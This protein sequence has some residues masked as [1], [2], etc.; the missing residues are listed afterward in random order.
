MAGRLARI[1]NRIISTQRMDMSVTVATGA[2][3]QVAELWDAA[4]Q[5]RDDAQYLQDWHDLSLRDP[6]DRPTLPDDT[7]E[8]FKRIRKNSQTPWG[9]MIVN[10][11]AQGIAVDDIYLRG[12][13][14]SSPAYNVWQQNGLD[15]KQTPLVKGM[16]RHGY[17]YNLILP[18]VGRLDG[19]PT[20]LIRGKSA[21]RM[22]AFYRDDAD[23]FPEFALEVDRNGEDTYIWLYDDVYTHRMSMQGDDLRT[24][25]Y[26]DNEPHGMSICPVVRYADMDLDGNTYGEIAPFI[27]VF[28]RIDQDTCDRLIV[29]R[30]GA[31]NAR[32]G[33]GVKQPEGEDA[34]RRLRL[35]FAAG[36]LMMSDEP[37][38]KFGSLP[39]TPLDGYIAARE[40]DIR[41]L[42]ATSQTAPYRLLG[43][44]DNV[45]GDA[46]AAADKAHN[47]KVDE[48]RRVVGEGHE[49]SLRLA[50][51]AMGNDEIAKDFTSRVHWVVIPS[52]SI[53]TLAQ[54]LGSLAKTVG[55][56]PQLLWDRVPGWDRSDTE[57]ALKLIEQ[58]KDEALLDQAEA[59]TVAE[60]AATTD[61]EATG[62]NAS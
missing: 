57:Q 33:T 43:L 20:A 41:D 52:E 28:R 34:Q 6:R 55:I 58:A 24:L 48:Y 9:R 50:G 14:E 60:A 13:R 53:Q 38:S 47:L 54:G 45:G 59:E 29:Q 56:P 35:A 49:A 32:Y 42:A 12:T 2:V 7:L 8:E 30:R 15:A 23:E 39:A 31:H 3:G 61:T 10:A 51:W 1:R 46:I 11:T 18:A 22:T 36:D 62:G 26:I 27:P 37:N 4:A 44:S 19:L 16:L 5:A 21:L 25:T 40:S 17:A